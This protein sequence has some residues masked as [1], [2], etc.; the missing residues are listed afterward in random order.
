MLLLLLTSYS[1]PLVLSP[2]QLS[3][4]VLHAPISHLPPPHADAALMKVDSTLQS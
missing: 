1:Q 3:Q 4:P 2:S